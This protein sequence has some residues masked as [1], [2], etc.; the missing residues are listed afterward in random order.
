MGD[1]ATLESEIAGL[2]AK[3]SSLNHIVYTA[4]DSLATIPIADAQLAQIKQAGMV[5]FFA[6]ILVAKHALKHLPA[7]AASSIT[8]TTGVVSEKPIPG[9]SVVNGFGTGL[10][11]TMRGLALDLKPIRVNLV[12]PGVVDTDLWAGMSQEQK[13]GMFK[14][15]EEK[16]ATGKVGQVEDVAEAFLYAMKDKNLTGSLISTNGGGLLM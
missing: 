11:G 4:G 7:S 5:R 16:L 1:E 6:P 8:L 13:E 12:S 3:T 10:H 14:T 15:F 2:F 9:W